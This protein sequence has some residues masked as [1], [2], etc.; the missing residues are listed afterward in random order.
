MYTSSSSRRRGHL[1]A[2]GALVAVVA[3]TLAACGSSGSSASAVSG[4]G[5]GQS[6]ASSQSSDSSAP[7]SAQSQSPS[8]AASSAQ[9]SGPGSE[10][11][12]V[13]A[14]T[15]GSAP[16]DFFTTVQ[17]ADTATLAAVQPDSLLAGQLPAKTKSSGTLTIGTQISAPETFYAPDGTTL[18]G[19]EQTLIKAI[20]KTLGLTPKFQVA[21]FAQLI[22]GLS[23]NR[24]DMTVGAMNDTKKRQATISFVDYFNAGIGFLAQKGNPKSVTGPDGFCGLAVTVQLGTTQEAFA[25]QQSTKCTDAGKKAIKIAY[26]PT[27][28][29]SLAALQ[30]GRADV[31]IVDSPTGAYIQSQHSDKFEQ[32]DPNKVYD[33]GP[34][35]LGFNKADPDLMKAVQGALNK[36]IADGTYAKVLQAWGLQSGAVQTA[37]INGGQ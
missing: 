28:D 1:V 25:K 37:T 22:P 12:S 32:I 6:S 11:P 29:E 27:D 7:E 3:M 13:S 23:S 33:S 24:Y 17:A 15:T 18:I 4:N 19:D 35:G 34:F 21:Q 5:S 8:D 14:S 36:L 26:A 30:S 31:Y 9:S 10:S 20:A 2:A 16:S